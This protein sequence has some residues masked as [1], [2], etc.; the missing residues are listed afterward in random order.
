MVEEVQADFR[1]AKIKAVVTGRLRSLLLDEGQLLDALADPNLDAVSTHTAMFEAKRLA[2][3]VAVM[4]SADVRQF[5]LKFVRRV[6][7]LEKR[8]FCRQF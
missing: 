5:I 4:A 3:N 1:D 8:F 2:D 6:E 7:V